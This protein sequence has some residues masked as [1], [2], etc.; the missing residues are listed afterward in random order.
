[1]SGVE[2]TV[3]CRACNRQVKINQVILDPIKKVYVCNACYT[4]AHPSMAP[5][6]RQKPVETKPSIFG[7]KKE[8]KEVILKYACLH[9]KYKFERKKGKEVTK[10]PY[11]GGTKIQE[12]SNEAAKILQDSDNFGF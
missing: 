11:C 7:G 6:S 4:R 2:Q 12:V 3:L 9:C 1:M 8:A 10:C 5:V